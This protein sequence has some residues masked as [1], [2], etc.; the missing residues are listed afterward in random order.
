MS[1]LTCDPIAPKI[2]LTPDSRSIVNQITYLIASGQLTVGAELPTI[3]SLAEQLQVTPN[4]I[5]KAYDS[6]GSKGLIVKR[7]G[8]GSFVAESGS[9][10]RKGEQRR[11]LTERIDGL[12][13]DARHFN[14]CFDEVLSLLQKRHQAMSKS[15]F[16]EPN[17][18]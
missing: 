15:N 10:L 3:R 18:E 11:I 12:L 16:K 1:H 13:A 8:V 4:T 7:H 17:C 2:H 6:L 14:F 5:V 9:P